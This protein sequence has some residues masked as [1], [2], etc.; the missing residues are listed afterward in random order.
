MIENR[1]LQFSINEQT[2]S[3]ARA[4]LIFDRTSLAGIPLT[5]SE[6]A[7]ALKQVEENEL[8][9]KLPFNKLSSGYNR[10]IEIGE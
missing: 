1:K 4:Y 5:E 7:Y 8:V 3:F 2:Q 10:K 9:V 6:S